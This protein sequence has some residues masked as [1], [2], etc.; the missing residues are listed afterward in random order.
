VRDFLK[1]AAIVSATIA[2]ALAVGVALL[3]ILLQFR[4]I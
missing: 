1:A 4:W 3:V 2:C